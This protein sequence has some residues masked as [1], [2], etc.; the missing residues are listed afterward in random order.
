MVHF[1]VVRVRKSKT[2]S[3]EGW[4][5]ERTAL[6]EIGGIVSPVFPTKAD[7]KVEADRLAAQEAKDDQKH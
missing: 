2:A 3:Q 6:G 1:R 4:A 7:A 5:V